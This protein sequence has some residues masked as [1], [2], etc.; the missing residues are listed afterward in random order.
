[1]IVKTH[2]KYQVVSH[3]TGRS[4]GTYD[5]KAEAVRRLRQIKGHANP[6]PPKYRRES[7]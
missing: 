4:F 7:R 5:S 3:Q 2:G 6:N 1:M